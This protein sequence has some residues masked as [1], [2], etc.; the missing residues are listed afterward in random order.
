MPKSSPL[1]DGSQVNCYAVAMA[2]AADNDMARGFD[3]WIEVG[4]TNLKVHRVLNSLLADLDLSLA[5]H[6]ILVAL[7]NRPGQTQQQ[8][9]NR[10]MLVKS[11]ASALIKKLEARGLLRRTPDP[12]DTR[13]KLVRLTK[14]GRALV[15]QSFALQNRVI[16]AMAEVM[17]DEDLARTLAVMRRVG[18]AVDKLKSD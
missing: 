8:L 1:L 5:Q 18:A 6:E 15:R 10:L 13:N 2:A 17:S 16:Q 14:P 12:D 3:V 7:K 11:N 9:S 4:R